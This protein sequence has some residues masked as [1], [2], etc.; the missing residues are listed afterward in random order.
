MEIDLSQIPSD[1]HIRKEALDI[2]RSY[3]VSAPAG[4]GKTSLLVQRILRLLAVAERPEEI[5]AITFTRKAAAEMRQRILEAL[6]EAASG[7]G[8]ESEHEKSMQEDALRVLERDSEQGWN[9]LQNP[10]RLRLQT[11][12]G[13]SSFLTQRLC[14]ETGT[15]H[16]GNLVE[17]PRDRFVQASEQL[18]GHINRPDQLGDAVRHLVQ[19][20]EGNQD[21]LVDLL[22][23]LLDSRAN[24]LD[25]VLHPEFG[26]DQLLQ[27]FQLLID[28]ELSAL[29]RLLVHLDT[30]ELRS[31]FEYSQKHLPDQIGA[32]DIQISDKAY[33]YHRYL[34]SWQALTNM[35]L[36]KKGEIRKPG[37]IRINVG[38]PPK[39]AGTEA[40]EML[41]R[42]KAFLVTLDD[43]TEL[44]EQLKRVQSLPAIDD[45]DKATNKTLHSLTTCLPVLAAELKLIFA[46]SGE[47][48]F[49]AISIS[50]LEALGEPD[51]PTSLNL[52]LDYRIRHILVDEFQDTSTLQV[53]LLERLTA[54]W[55]SGDGRTLFLVGDAMQSIYGFRKAN[56]ALFIRAREL[57][58]GTT[59]PVSLDLRANF[60]SAPA[61]VDW[62]N[63]SFQNIL[64]LADDRTR[65]RVSYRASTAQRPIEAEAAV[66]LSGFND[67]RAEAEQLAN[68]IQQQLKDSECSIAILIR[69]RSHLK[70]ILP[71]LKARDI[72]WQAQKIEPLGQRMH[73]L[74]LHS[75]ARALHCPAD[76]IAWL[77][78][79][80]S[81]FLALDMSDLYA[82][83]NPAQEPASN[84][85]WINIYMYS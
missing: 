42:I 61:I 37:G 51:N 60:R 30:G 21:A 64:P 32:E 6:R 13:F 34:N 53:G 4:S 49:S 62:V 75:L 41:E 23:D 28:G 72:R 81:P 84:C 59:K 66:D 25:L 38:F 55:E 43:Q 83:A 73:V 54:G 52:R 9:L 36:T 50:A 35:L 48:D 14:L 44:I 18:V 16:P 24:W 3:A 10:E 7:L 85:L 77:A 1:L 69:A 29:R 63:Q 67:S 39:S 15:S 70:E 12:D 80:R 46:S 20:F 57:G 19:H 45:Q 33:S 58:I 68:T 27:N 71:Q 2:S 17:S 56:V 31:L 82:L 11:I 47:A 40:A 5:L 74:D 22:A 76:R 65:S 79:L 8:V 26:Q 78:L